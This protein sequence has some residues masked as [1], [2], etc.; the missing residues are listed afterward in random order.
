MYQQKSAE[1]KRNAALTGGTRTF[2]PEQLDLQSVLGDLLGGNIQN[3]GQARQLTGAGNKFNFGEF[4]RYVQKVQPQFKPLQAQIGTNALSFARGE[5][6]N[7]TVNSI[8]RAA[9]ERGIQGGFGFGSQGAKTGALANLNLRNLGLTS[10]DLSKYGTGLAMQANQS[11]KGLMPQLGNAF[12]WLFGPTQGL[13]AAEFNLDWQ[14]RAQLANVST[15]NAIGQNIAD[16]KY[17]ASLGQ[18]ASV[19]QAGNQ[20]SSLL[21]G[22]GRTAGSGGG[23]FGG[24]Y[25]PTGTGSATFNGKAIPRATL[26]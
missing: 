12:D 10:L 18:A 20:L 25:S 21:G 11:A 23:G 7:D 6:P 17:A 4:M 9:A 15:G 5:L 1:K 14:N 16:Q 2:E 24:D 8:G 19:Q 3:F 26:A 22:Y 13:Q